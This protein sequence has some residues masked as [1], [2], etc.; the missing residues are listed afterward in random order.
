MRSAEAQAACWRESPCGRHWCRRA[1]KPAF[2]ARLGRSRIAGNSG[3]CPSARRV[4]IA[5][6]N[7]PRLN[8]PNT[9][10]GHLFQRLFGNSLHRHPAL[11]PRR[12]GPGG[13]AKRPQQRVW[14]LT[15]SIFAASGS[16]CPC[17][18]SPPL[19]GGRHMLGRSR[20]PSI[21]VRIA[22]NPESPRVRSTIACRERPANRPVRLIRQDSGIWAAPTSALTALNVRPD[23]PARTGRRYRGR[24]GETG[25]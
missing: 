1:C 2:P 7:A 16:H 18:N 3:R 4:A 14:F 17:R 24:N 23:L 15:M 21:S 13:G 11:V 22:H 10:S 19:R 20:L 25:R 6:V 8:S 12:I 5:H 9:S